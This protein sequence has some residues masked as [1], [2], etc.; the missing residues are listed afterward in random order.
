MTKVK[1]C[2]LKCRQHLN[3]KI[4]TYDVEHDLNNIECN[5]VVDDAL[6][7]LQE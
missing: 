1:A 6:D 3:F 2:N 4:D 5:L 7:L